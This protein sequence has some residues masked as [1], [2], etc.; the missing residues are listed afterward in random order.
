M[1]TWET[2]TINKD[3]QTRNE[4]LENY[5]P[6][7]R[8]VARNLALN[9]PNFISEDDL[10]SY[11]IFGLIDAIERFDSTRGFKFETFAVPR[12]KGSILDELRTLDW[13]PRSIRAKTNA[14]EKLMTATE[15]GAAMS[16][17][18]AAEF[19]GMTME[20]FHKFKTDENS[21]Y[22]LSLDAELNE[23]SGE[24]HFSFADMIPD[25]RETHET[26]IEYNHIVNTLV[27][28]INMLPERERILLYLYYYE[29]MTLAEIGKLMKITES[30]V[31]QIHTSVCN[32][33]KTSLHL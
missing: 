33:L 8:K 25:E 31:C 26:I 11:G 20:D 2:Y 29:Q 9:M 17:Q 24:E 18:E 6:L 27:Q 21:A 22:M 5:I 16:E 3:I 14:I 1:I 28:T 4:I 15:H 7:V 32:S 10:V 30:R 12:I 23:I 19:L 13:A